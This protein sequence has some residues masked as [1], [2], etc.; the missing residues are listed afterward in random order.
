LLAC[1]LIVFTTGA[2]AQPAAPR[3]S[4]LGPTEP[5]G[6]ERWR[7]GAGPF[8]L[9]PYI[10]IGEIA[11]DTNVF[12]VPEERTTD[13]VANG[14]P[15]LRIDVPVGRFVPYVDGNVNYYWFA[16]TKGLRHFGGEA[17][18]GF[19][20]LGNA[21]KVSASQY[22]ERT[23][24]RPSIEVDTRILQDT[25]RTDVGMDLS[26][27]ARVRLEPHFSIDD[28]EVVP[29]SFLGA[30]LRQSQS[31]KRTLAEL[32]VKYRLTPK[33]DF[34]LVGDQDWARYPYD[35][36]RDVDSNRVG[37]GFELSSDT[38]LSGRAVG[39]ARHFRPLNTS[40][41][42]SFVR[43]WADVDFRWILGSKTQ[44]GARYSLETTY[45]AFDT[46]ETSLPLIESQIAGIYFARQLVRRVD[47][48]TGFELNT[49]T[50]NVPVVIR[51]R[52]TEVVIARDDKF[53]SAHAELGVRILQRLRLAG[54]AT[55]NE[56][57]S[58]YDDFG[59]EGLLLGAKLTF[60]P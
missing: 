55:Y 44:V 37:A 54:T 26:A 51:Q 59:L 46:T 19:D 23:F 48:R 5:G 41:G 25:W 3:P 45:S 28:S 10:R 30:E 35:A 16:R 34:V 6:A 60:N 2:G 39:G 53:Y 17:G 43:P 12:Y 22:F 49:F 36:T 31:I 58:N 24:R 27:G 40:R 57:Q 9:S 56:R 21:V 52:G 32:D 20:W 47:F 33:T 42:E 7:F 4:D 18:G 8:V 14:G 38:R 15:G 29:E 50:N 1:S 13:L 11:V